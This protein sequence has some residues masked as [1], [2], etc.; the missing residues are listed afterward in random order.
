MKDLISNCKMISNIHDEICERE[1]DDKLRKMYKIV[2]ENLFFETTTE[3][4]LEDIV[5]DL[6]K[7]CLI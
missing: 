3:Q 7:K 6:I 5:Q 4:T 2:E 1:D